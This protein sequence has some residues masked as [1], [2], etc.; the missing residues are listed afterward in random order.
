ME[1]SGNSQVFYFKYSKVEDLVDVL[2][3]VSG[4]FMVVK[5]EVEG[6]VGSGCE[7]VFIVVSKYSNVL[8]VI[9]LQ[10]I[11]QLL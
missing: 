10:D 7:V 6:M 2:K 1:C 4:M 8:I 3:Q 11:M 9:V 5:E